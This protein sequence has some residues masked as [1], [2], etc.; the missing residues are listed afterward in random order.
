MIIWWLS[1]MSEKQWNLLSPP[2][3]LQTSAAGCVVCD[4][5]TIIRPSCWSMIVCFLNGNGTMVVFLRRKIV[6]SGTDVYAWNHRR[7]TR[8]VS[9]C[10]SCTFR[11]VTNMFALCKVQFDWFTC[12]WTI[13][14]LN[15]LCCTF[16]ILTDSRVIERLN[17]WT[18]YVVLCCPFFVF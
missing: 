1:N 7:R 18:N 15:E 12:D 10:F 17:D 14:R 6:W 8:H 2:F 4:V 13:E 11:R 16:C 9:A 5:N 3:L